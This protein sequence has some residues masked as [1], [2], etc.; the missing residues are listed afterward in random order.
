LYG[1]PSPLSLPQL[2]TLLC[3][4]GFAGRPMFDSSFGQSLQADLVG[5]ED[6]EG[7]AL[8]GLVSPSSA[9]ET[10]SDSSECSEDSHS[11]L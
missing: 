8:A 5:L 4:C 9:Y 3:V 2:S 11:S 1:K 7:C 6:E 10:D